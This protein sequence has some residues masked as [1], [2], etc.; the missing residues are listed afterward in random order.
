MQP[1]V[2]ALSTML[3]L[4]LVHAAVIKLQQ[5]ARMLRVLH[6]FAGVPPRWVKPA[7]AIAVAIELAAAS[8]LV[9]PST[10]HLGAG[11]AAALWLCYTSL[12]LRALLRG[13]PEVDCGCDS[14]AGDRPLDGM[15]IVRT[16]TLAAAAT[17]VAWPSFATVPAGLQ[18]FLNIVAG[19]ASFAL[20]RTWTL[21]GGPQP[22]IESSL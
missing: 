20:Y 16:A 7:Y 9:W 12:Q 5:R 11:T 14:T 3:A 19:T 6:E 10:Q 8:A 13:H 17:I 15:K 21:L 18:V 22:T 2:G 1:L 4:M